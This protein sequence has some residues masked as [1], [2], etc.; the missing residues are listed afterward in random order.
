MAL[1]IKESIGSK[2]VVLGKI[3]GFLNV[4]LRLDLRSLERHQ[5]TLKC[6]EET[7]SGFVVGS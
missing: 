1:D 5:M 7:G 2:I 3:R 6:F 4:R